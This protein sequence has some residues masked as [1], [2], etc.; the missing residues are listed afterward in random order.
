[1]TQWHDNRDQWGKYRSFEKPVTDPDSQPP[2]EWYDQLTRRGQFVAVILLLVLFIGLVA[3][4][5]GIET[6]TF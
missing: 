4:V 5:G 3:L 6:G 1:M 2:K